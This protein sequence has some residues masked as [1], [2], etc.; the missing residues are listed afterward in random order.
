MTL[1]VV[2]EGAWG[3]RRQFS[4]TRGLISLTHLLQLVQAGTQTDPP[5][6]P[7]GPHF[8]GSS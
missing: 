1:V 7:P 6:P 2:E 3:A 5:P 8:L 4:R